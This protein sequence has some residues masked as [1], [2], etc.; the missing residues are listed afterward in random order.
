MLILISGDTF[1]SVIK[2]SKYGLHFGT[3]HLKARIGN[4]NTLFL[5]ASY[6]ISPFLFG[7]MELVCERIVLKFL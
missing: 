3:Y 6:R 2:I 7:L 1:G 4:R 5:L